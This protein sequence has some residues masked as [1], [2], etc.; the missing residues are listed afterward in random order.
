M[1]SHFGH[2]F[3]G[4]RVH[5]DEK[6][7]RSASAMGSSAYT[8][9]TD[10]AFAAGQ[11]APHT[12]AGRR[13]LAHELAHVQQ[14]RGTVKQIQRYAVAERGANVHERDAEHMADAIAD[15]GPKDED[16]AP[17]AREAVRGGG[18]SSPGGCVNGAWKYDYDGC[19]MPAW[20]ANALNID[21]NN[22]A[23][24]KD[25][26]FAKCIPSAQ[27]GTGCDRHDECYQT[28]GASK[29]S[30]ETAFKKDLISICGASRE[31]R[32]VK[33]RCY[34]WARRYYWAVKYRGKKAFDDRQAALKQCARRGSV[35]PS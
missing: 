15:A 9:G 33:T 14:Q 26:Q 11:Y 13:L 20:L 31:N 28:P 12:P 25:T 16:A 29:E 17:A 7:A 8:I 18:C 30:C 6:A 24:G 23:G 22:P 1:E 32:S 21:A 5:T 19:S 3:S 35:A 10:I 27:G 2:D 34:R 4:I